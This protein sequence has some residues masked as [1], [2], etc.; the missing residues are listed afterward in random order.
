MRIAL[1]IEYNGAN[2][3]GWQRQQN[4]STIQLH[5][6]NAISKV[7]NHEIKVICAGRTDVGVHAFLQVVH[8]D[9][10]S[11]R[12]NYAWLMGINTYLP[13]DI[14]VQWVK[15]VTEEFHARF[16]ALSR[17]YRY[18]IYNNQT[19]SAHYYRKAT[20]YPRKLNADLMHEAAQFLVG[21]HDFSSFRGIDCQSK[22][23]KRNLTLL[24][25][26][27][28]DKLIIIDIKANAFLMHMVRNIVGVLVEIGLSHRPPIWAKEVLL[29]CDRKAAAVTAPADGLYFVKAEYP[30]EF[31]L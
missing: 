13:P 17:H 29:C 16:S 3:H 27:R 21:E 15:F 20:W 22:S 19:N 6:E 30:K 12:S 4:L 23:T 18:F 31:S 26:E 7:A 2:Y 14:R 24:T 28:K 10:D 9:T 5:L 11:V 1:G 8:F 25:V